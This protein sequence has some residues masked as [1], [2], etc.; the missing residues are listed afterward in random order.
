MKGL[1]GRENCLSLLTPTLRLRIGFLRYRSA[2]FAQ[3]PQPSAS[4]GG[5]ICFKI[6][7]LSLR[8]SV[9]RLRLGGQSVETIYASARFFVKIEHIFVDARKISASKSIRFQRAC[10]SLMDEK[11]LPETAFSFINRI[12][13]TMQQGSP[14]RTSHLC[15]YTF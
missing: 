2:I 4:L 5:G 10:C 11:T 12:K 14:L 9:L 6:A 15:V 1:L 7:P 13:Q 3:I 8:N